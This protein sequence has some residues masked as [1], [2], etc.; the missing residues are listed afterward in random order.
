[1][2]FCSCAGLVCVFVCGH[3]E[4]ATHSIRSS[5]S[6]K[7]RSGSD[8][9]VV[10]PRRTFRYTSHWLR[11]IESTFTHT[12]NVPTLPCGSR[13]AANIHSSRPPAAPAKSL[14]TSPFARTIQIAWKIS[15]FLFEIGRILLSFYY[16]FV[17][18]T[19][20]YVLNGVGLFDWIDLDVFYTEITSVASWLSN[21]YITYPRHQQHQIEPTQLIIIIISY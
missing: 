14:F 5:K 9:L 18:Q 13:L 20:V 17:S 1:M 15:Y 19:I 12:A 16:L 10:P 6:A 8:R 21:W 2:G 11:S 4:W 3:R 7:D